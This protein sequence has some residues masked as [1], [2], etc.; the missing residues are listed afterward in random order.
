MV[1]GDKYTAVMLTNGR[2]G[3]CANS[4]NI[5]NIVLD[6]NFALDLT[7]TS[8]RILYNAYVNAHL[9]TYNEK[10]KNQDIFTR[11]DFTKYSNIV[12]IGYFK[13][14][15]EKFIKASI[16]LKIFDLYQ[17]NE[18]ITPP[19][20]KAEYIKNA[21]A[22]LL[23]ATSIFNSSFLP[24]C[25]ETKECCDIYV[26]GPSSIIH[27]DILKYKNI[28]SIFGTIFKRNDMR[29]LDSI[30]AGNGTRHFQK[31]GKKVNCEF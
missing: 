22:I 3:V 2:I 27:N 16:E 10:S 31:F 19:K 7:V 23:T 6:D 14:V 24:I 25:Q 30:K 18:F 17:E 13:P 20:Y 11:V 8:H 26:L 9:N 12:M 28:K 1:V 5:I 4:G 15:I 29:V 21:D